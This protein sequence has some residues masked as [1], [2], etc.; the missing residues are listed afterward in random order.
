MKLDTAKLEKVKQRGGKII[1]AC[2]A[3][4]EIGRDTGGD[5]L[6]I[7]DDGR[8]ACAAFQ[9]DKEHARRILE[10]V[11]REDWR[12]TRQ[13]RHDL[14][15]PEKP[16]AE[17]IDWNQ[18]RQRL[19]GTPDAIARLA[20][21]RGWPLE[22]VERLA[23]A[24]VLGLHGGRICFPVCMDAGR[25]EPVGRHV[26]SW[27]EERTGSQAKGDAWFSPAGA[28][29]LPPL[30]LGWSKQPR[31]IA[32]MESQWDALSVLHALR[33]DG[34]ARERPFIVTRGTSPTGALTTAL[35]GVETVWLWMQ[36]DEPKT[37]GSIPAEQWL[38]RCLSLLPASV[39][40]L[41]RVDP[42]QG[43]KDWNDAQRR[44]APAEFGRMIREAKDHAIK[45]QRPEMAAADDSLP[46]PLP[47]PSS[48]PSVPA[49]D[50]DKLLPLNLRGYVQDCA[51]RLQVDP[52]FVAVPLIVS[53]GSVLGNR[54]GLRPKVYDD[55]TE[56][57]NIWGAIMGR[58]ATLKSPSLSAALRFIEKLERTANEAHQESRAEW[59]Q[60]QGVAKI[61]R[62]AATE[63]AK[64]AVKQGKDFDPASLMLDEEEETGP[65]LRRFTCNDASPESLHSI[66]SRPENATGVLLFTDELSGLIARMNDP[67]RGA[68][69]RSFLLSGWNGYQPAVVDRIGRGENLRV[70]RCCISVLGGIQPGKLAPLV[71]AAVKESAQDDGWLQRFSL[72]VYPDAPEDFRC[73]DRAPDAASYAE[74][75]GIFERVEST[76]GQAW[77]GAEQDPQRGSWFIRFEPMAADHFKE[78]M[79]TETKALRAGDLGA[80]V[81]SHF[82]KY[83]KAVCAL[84]LL[85]HVATEP[86]HTAVSLVCL[87]RALAWLDYLKPHALRVYGSRRNDT[88][89]AAARILDRLRKRDL[90]ERF[91]VHQLKRPCWS[92]LT[93]GDTIKAALAMLVD[94]GWLSESEIETGGRPRVDYLTHPKLFTE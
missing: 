10:L 61:R 17:S 74:V 18:D 37:D 3:C 86:D 91:T 16:K 47:L 41:W 83:R 75:M 2:P 57:A 11:G 34:S 62:Q 13:K 27:Q 92:G 63:N 93:D 25:G 19:A 54:L 69:L 7:F 88:A 58:P 65:P 42:P 71:D 55:Y 49:F 85:F 15:C 30:L 26:F 21:W 4:V 22:Y 45:I 24:G 28:K 31:E 53:L 38:N 33:W 68:A 78:W 43:F 76:H 51:E 48:L 29:P 64:K 14:P 9:T 5:N 8:F 87:M 1:A 32:L 46:D 81:E 23:S 90:P 72:L 59:K 36:R 20:A 35:E 40:H 39:R 89:K 94:H 70:D 79:E 66:L 12:E 73:I 60:E 56:F 82:F 44:I 84:A 6:A 77:P 80:A 67:E 50:C 52:A